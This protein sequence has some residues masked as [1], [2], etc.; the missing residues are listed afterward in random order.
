MAS[1][2]TPFHSEASLPERLQSWLGSRLFAGTVTL[3]AGRE[4]VLDVQAVGYADLA[5]GKPISRNSLFW[6][7]SVSKPI[8]ATALMI[9]VDEG[10]IGLDDPVESHLPEFA[11]QQVVEPDG[12]FRKPGHPIRILEI[13]SHTSGLPF[14]LKSEEPTFDLLPLREAVRGYA[15]AALQFEPGSDYRYSNA[16]INTAGRIIEVVSGMPYEAFLEE[17][18]FAP[19]GMPDTTFTPNSEQAARLAKTYRPSA[20]GGLEEIPISQVK[21]PVDGPGRYPFPGGGLFST[22]N[23]LGRFGT[24]L[25]NGGTLDGHRYL[26]EAALAEMTRRQTPP[27]LSQSYG[28]GWSVGEGVFH[29]G[30]AY[31]NDLWIDRKRGFAAVF[32]VQHAGDWGNGEGRDILPAFRTEAARLATGNEAA[33]GSQTS[34][35]SEGSTYR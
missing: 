18:L 35:V 21:Y 33:D 29:H 2:P 19:L 11:G 30:G 4:G 15:A 7:A 14:S 34:V 3:V 22:A 27:S 28:L 9:L 1:T 20:S 17:R 26:S 25:L 24:M 16:G 5:A 6:I 8:T 32:L 31:Q 12:S 13:L 23:D 10:K